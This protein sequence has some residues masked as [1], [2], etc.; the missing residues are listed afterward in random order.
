MA[1]LNGKYMATIFSVDFTH[2]KILYRGDPSEKMLV[3]KGPSIENAILTM[4]KKIK[5]LKTCW[6]KLANK[7]HTNQRFKKGAFIVFIA[8]WLF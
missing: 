2:F 3:F 5:N 6:N 8:S 1:S 4:I 7:I